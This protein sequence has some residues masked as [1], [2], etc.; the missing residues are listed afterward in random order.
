M[1]MDT[2]HKENYALDSF[3]KIIQS[4]V[5]ALNLDK[6][7][8]IKTIERDTI[9]HDVANAIQ[10]KIA[11][12]VKACRKSCIGKIPEEREIIM[13]T[14][15]DK[16]EEMLMQD[17][18]ST[19]DNALYAKGKLDALEKVAEDLH[20]TWNSGVSDLRRINEVADMIKLGEEPINGR[21]RKPGTR[22][23]KLSVVR[24]AQEEVEKNQV[25][26][27]GKA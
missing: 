10:K 24:K 7:D 25:E 21:N 26:F 5:T 18:A 9:I 6:V 8:L 3:E 4:H 27:D 11:P 16:I 1:R 14:T 15:I 13:M 22:P 23:E 17:V 20:V 12:L 19:R 2:Q